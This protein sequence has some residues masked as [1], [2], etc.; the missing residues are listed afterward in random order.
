MRQLADDSKID[1]GDSLK[2]GFTEF[3]KLIKGIIRFS[4]ESFI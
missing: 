3:I 2:E 1:F 4:P